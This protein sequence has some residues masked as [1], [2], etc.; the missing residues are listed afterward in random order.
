[1]KFL[2]WFVNT[3]WSISSSLIETANRPSK[4]REILWCGMCWKRKGAQCRN[5]VPHCYGD[6]FR[7]K[8]SLVMLWLCVPIWPINFRLITR[9]FFE[10]IPSISALKRHTFSQHNS[11]NCHT[12]QFS[13]AA[14]AQAITTNNPPGFKSWESFTFW[15]LQNQTL[16]FWKRDNNYS[17]SQLYLVV[18][19]TRTS[20]GRGII[21]R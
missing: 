14:Y 17:P 4:H 19:G 9:R 21:T 8:N 6:V 12:N 2:L 20:T 11:S 18:G 7:Y 5:R 10:R 1:M 16:W 3:S 13:C 15:G